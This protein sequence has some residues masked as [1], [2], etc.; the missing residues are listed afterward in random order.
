M[1]SPHLKVPPGRGEGSI[2][3]MSPESPRT[4]SKN[5]VWMFCCVL[6]GGSRKILPTHIL[7]HVLLSCTHLYMLSSGEEA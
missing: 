6:I 1:F 2:S 3:F 7:W 4:D 5:A